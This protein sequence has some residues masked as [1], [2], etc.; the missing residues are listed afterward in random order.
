MY[1]YI[2]IIT[3]RHLYPESPTT[4]H[5]YTSITTQFINDFRVHL[6]PI[7]LIRS[8]DSVRKPREAYCH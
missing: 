1:Y 7:E 2:S 5:T 6:I 8:I 3:N 4:Q